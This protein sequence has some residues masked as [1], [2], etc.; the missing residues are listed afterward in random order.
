[1]VDLGNLDGNDEFLLKNSLLKFERSIEL[2]N[3]N[4]DAYYNWGTALFKMGITTNIGEFFKE[5]VK[6]FKL[7]VSLNSDFGLAFNNLSTALIYCSYL[8]NEVGKKILILKEAEAAAIKSYDIDRVTYNLA[9]VNVLMNNKQE[10]LE[11]LKE[12]LNKKEIE[13]EHVLNDRD[14]DAL[15]QD[16]DFLRVMNQ[17]QI[18]YKNEKP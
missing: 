4:A 13:C 15:K 16:K 9:C 5:S 3:K 2:N 8:E 6:K 1:M 7:T 10:A 12:S 11:Y 18:I 17:Y 14:W